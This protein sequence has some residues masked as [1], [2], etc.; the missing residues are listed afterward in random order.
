MR[1]FPILAACLALIGIALVALG[2]VG[3]AE[4]Y[5]RKWE[6]VTGVVLVSA[7]D[8]ASGMDSVEV[9]IEYRYENETYRSSHQVSALWAVEE[10]PLGEEV[11]VR[12]D[13]QSPG[14]ARIDAP[15]PATP[16]MLGTLGIL[17]I[18]AGAG[19]FFLGR[20]GP[21]TSTQE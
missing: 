9:Q 3:V 13:P 20:S 7:E 16:L 11:T 5:G 4:H 1:L 14:V 21:R 18:G 12:V 17:F 8:S 6:E 10:F 15:S 19:V 2:G